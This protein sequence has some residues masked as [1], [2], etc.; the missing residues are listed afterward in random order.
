M[1]SLILP[2]AL[3]LAAAPLAVQSATGA[4]G[5]DPPAV[6]A[7]LD[8]TDQGNSEADRTIT[9]EIRKS[10][11]ANDDLSTSAK[12]VKIITRDGVVTLRGEVESAQE[13]STI[14]AVSTRTTGV[15]RV[16]NQIEVE[17]ADAD[18]DADADLD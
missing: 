16:D 10:L 17:R 7:P 1:K 15:K 11:V 13:K 6:G 5:D 12:N 9:A 14:A 18:V 2:L 8:P 3:A 4:E